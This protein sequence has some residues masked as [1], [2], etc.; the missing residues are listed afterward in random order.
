MCRGKA[1]ARWRSAGTPLPSNGHGR[2][3]APETVL[4]LLDLS[5][6]PA[7]EDVR[8]QNAVFAILVFQHVAL[9]REDQCSCQHVC[10][11]PPC[12]VDLLHD[13]A[14][15]QRHLRQR[16]WQHHE[17]DPGALLHL[18]HVPSCRPA[19]QA[20]SLHSHNTGPFRHNSFLFQRFHQVLCHRRMPPKTCVQQQHA[21]RLAL[22]AQLVAGVVD[23]RVQVRSVQQQGLHACGGRDDAGGTLIRPSA[24]APTARNVDG[25]EELQDMAQYLFGNRRHLRQ[26]QRVRQGSI[27]VSVEPEIAKLIQQSSYSQI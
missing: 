6:G 26:A 10:A 4:H 22:N 24:G 27:A 1:P 14:V 3:L 8:R 13:R 23:H 16:L 21:T 17:Q 5:C 20:K 7:A 18:H 25:P 12:A 2:R 11:S 19:Q 9:I 15:A